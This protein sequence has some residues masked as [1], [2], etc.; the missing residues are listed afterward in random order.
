MKNSKN[1]N[2][3]VAVNN[4]EGIS[5]YSSV[6]S[7]AV[8]ERFSEF[9][10]VSEITLRAYS[11]GIKQCITFCTSN[12]I[13]QPNRNTVLLFKKTLIKN[14]AKPST[15]ALYLS[16]LRRFFAWCESEGLYENI[17]AGVKSP[18][19]DK[20]HKKDALS[21]SQIKACLQSMSRET[22]Q[23]ARDYA[24]F[25]LMAT[26]GLRTCEVVRADVADIQQVQGVPVLFVH[27]KG[28]AGKSDFVKLSE[29]VC[30]A[31]REYLRMRGQVKRDEPLFASCSKRNRGQRL[32]T[33][34]VSSVAK[35]AMQSAGYNSPRLTAHSLR[36]S[37]ATLALQGGMTL[38]DVSEF[39][40]HSSIAITM[41]Y[42]HSITV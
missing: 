38:E 10:D 34:T 29:P 21:G 14:S 3:L 8:I 2:S 39:L 30:D 19:Q 41:V 32:T 22:R 4:K 40:R 27:G 6:L 28:R 11:S 42:V 24:M 9:L 7:S 35:N 26:A 37:A 31:L 18:K 36:H 23:G 16:A 15:V 25:L 13:S 12:R 17:T 5:Q 1:V 20:G 33:R